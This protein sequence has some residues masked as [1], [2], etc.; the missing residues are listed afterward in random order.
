MAIPSPDRNAGLPPRALTIIFALLATSFG[1]G[2]ALNNLIV[3]KS[4]SDAPMKK[5]TGIGGFFLNART[6]TK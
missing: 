6:P 3:N 5:V 2:F 1:L 4:N